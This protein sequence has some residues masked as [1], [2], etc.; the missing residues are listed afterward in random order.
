VVKAQTF[1]M[2]FAEIW[3]SHNN[4]HGKGGR[5]WCAHAPCVPS[6]RRLFGH[7]EL[8]LRAVCGHQLCSRLFW[9]PGTC[10]ECRVRPRSRICANH[11]G[12]IRKY[13]LNICRQCFRE[14]AKDIG[15]VKARGRAPQSLASGHC[16]A[17]WSLACASCCA[18]WS[19][20]FFSCCAPWSSAF[21]YCCTVLLG[22]GQRRGA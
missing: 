6:R 10:A 17:P 4:T 3:D 13:G 8:A 16:C 20:A 7:Q 1:A 15:F 11:W 19:L 12:L 21:V 18:P 14:Y 9:T 5:Q 22:A 2:G